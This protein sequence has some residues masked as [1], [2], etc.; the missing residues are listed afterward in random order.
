MIIMVA[1]AMVRQAMITKKTKERFL[2]LPAAI[3][4]LAL[5]M[6]T[7][8]TPKAVEINEG[9]ITY[10]QIKPIIEAR[11]LQ[12]HSTHNT[13]DTWKVAPKGSIFETEQQIIQNK[14]KMRR[15]VRMKVMP[16]GNKTNMTETE[17]AMLVKYLTELR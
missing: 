15:Q 11:C 10:Q 12:C 4:L 9:I 2:V 16:L 3:G 5:V 14:K 17:R 7:S 13:D 6:I 1:G 8:K